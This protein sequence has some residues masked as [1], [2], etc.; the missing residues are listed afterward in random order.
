MTAIAHAATHVHAC[1]ASLLQTNDACAVMRRGGRS[2]AF[3]LG[4][5]GIPYA[6][7]T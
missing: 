5:K 3:L 2:A 1:N 7:G 6:C 4:C